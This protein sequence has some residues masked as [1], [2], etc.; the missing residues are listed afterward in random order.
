[1]QGEG[2][3]VAN[4][5]AGLADAYMANAAA[6]A[7]LMEAGIELMQQ[8]LRRRNPT[9]DEEQI[10]AMLNDWL[11]RGDDPIPGDTAGAVRVRERF[12]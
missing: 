12:V 9:A 11:R 7:V 10:R 8:N 6:A 4:R 1:M 2:E 3:S 5:T